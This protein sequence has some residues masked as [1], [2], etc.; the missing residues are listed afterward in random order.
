MV[1]PFTRGASRRS[2][3]LVKLR[4]LPMLRCP[5]CESGLALH[6]LQSRRFSLTADAAARADAEAIERALLETAVETGVLACIGGCAWYPIMKFVPVLLDFHLPLHDEFRARHARSLKVLDLPPPGGT[7]RPGEEQTQKSFTIE[8][9]GLGEDRHTFAFTLPER[10]RHLRAELDWPPELLSRPLGAPPLQVLD[11]GSGFG[12]EPIYIHNATGGVSGGAEVVGLDLNLSLLESGPKI[13][14]MPFVHNV[15]ASLFA[16]PFAPRSFDL[17][18]SNGVLHHTYSTEA[19]LRSIERFRKADGAL[20]VWL[21][22]AEDFFQMRRRGRIGYVF[23][24]WLRP[25]FSRLPLALQNAI[26]YPLACRNMR[27]SRRA[28]G[29]G[30][31]WTIKNALHDARDRWTPR[32]AHRH[33]F[34][35][36]LRWFSEFGLEARPVDPVAIE[37]ALPIPIVGIG[38]RGRAKRFGMSPDVLTQPARR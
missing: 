13:A 20:Y 31:D 33:R 5:R 21:Y 1:W 4:L 9:S 19:A 22:A 18:Y 24:S 23:E 17:V 29:R 11:I 2:S 30:R 32:Y 12:L 25:Q 8:W 34:N 14:A 15:I 16:P 6:A 38:L 28:L 7:P 3:S 36:V 10:E 27:V 26:L 37:S 35:E